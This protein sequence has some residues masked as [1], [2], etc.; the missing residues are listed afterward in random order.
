MRLTYFNL[1]SLGSVRF[2]CGL[3]GNRSPIRTVKKYS[4][5]MKTLSKTT[6]WFEKVIITQ[7][8]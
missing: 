5:V 6:L 7:K 3:F 2:D 1:N 8:T 4:I